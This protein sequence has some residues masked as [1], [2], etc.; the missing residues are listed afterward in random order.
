MNRPLTSL[1]CSWKQYRQRFLIL[2]RLLWHPPP[3]IVYPHSATSRMCSLLQHTPYAATMIGG[4]LSRIRGSDGGC[5]NRLSTSRTYR[6]RLACII[7]NLSLCT[8][9]A[10]CLKLLQQHSFAS[11]YKHMLSVSAFPESSWYLGWARTL[12]WECKECATSLSLR[13]IRSI[14]KYHP[15]TNHCSSLHHH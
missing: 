4:L 9:L 14:W 8:C 5:L 2:Y 10:D 11:S 6:L 12:L 15:A 1:M 7:E 13:W 3:N